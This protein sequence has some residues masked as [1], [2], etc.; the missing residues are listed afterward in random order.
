MKNR[1]QVAFDLGS[2]SIKGA[3]GRIINEN[4]IEILSI[5]SVKTDSIDSGDIIDKESLLKSLEY[6]IEKME[7][8]AKI[9]IDED[10]PGQTDDLVD[11]LMGKKPELRFQYIQENAK[12]VEDLDV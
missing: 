4:Q 10:E 11:R 6:L 9:N 1:I 8:D 2:F 3:V 5:R 7:K 12:F